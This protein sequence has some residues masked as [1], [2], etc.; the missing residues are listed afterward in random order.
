[1][2]ARERLGNRRRNEVR[3]NSDTLVLAL[4]FAPDSTV[5]GA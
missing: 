4:L 1:M 3:S 5:T 2:S